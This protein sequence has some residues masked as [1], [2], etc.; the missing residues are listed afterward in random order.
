MGRSTFGG[1][2]SVDAAAGSGSSDTS[3]TSLDSVTGSTGVGAA[4]EAVAACI[5]AFLPQVECSGRA[6]GAVLGEVDGS[7]TGCSAADSSEGAVAAPPV[8]DAA[9]SA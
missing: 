3:A 8:D 4:A 1:S 9:A 7:A 6:G 2:V 5:G